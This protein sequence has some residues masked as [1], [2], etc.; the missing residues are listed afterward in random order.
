MIGLGRYLV[1]TDTKHLGQTIDNGEITR[2]YRNSLYTVNGLA[3]HTHYVC[4]MYAY[5]V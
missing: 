3:G 2:A 5:I 4:H 1:Q